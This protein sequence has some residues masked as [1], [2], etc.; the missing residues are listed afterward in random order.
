MT[1][2]LASNIFFLRNL[3]NIVGTNV[4]MLAFHA[5]IMSHCIYGI[6]VWGHSPHSEV[7]FRLQ[8]RAMRVLSNIGYR[9]DVS[10]KFKEFNILTIPSLYIYKCMCYMHCNK[11]R[12][13][14]HNNIHNY[15]TRYSENLRIPSL[16]LSHSK[17]MLNYYGSVFYN[18]INVILKKYIY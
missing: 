16:R 15:T 4:L 12:Y 1:K 6:T 18:K 13:L 10:E 14:Q 11:H 5:L 2:K 17:N 3:K 9:E 7:V 8:R